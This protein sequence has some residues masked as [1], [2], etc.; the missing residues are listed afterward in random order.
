MGGTVQDQFGAASVAEQAELSGL[1]ARMSSSLLPF[2]D[3]NGFRK[4]LVVLTEPGAAALKIIPDYQ[5]YSSQPS[6]LC[7]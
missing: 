6:H 5:R 2:R 1:N 4:L 3:S 7:C